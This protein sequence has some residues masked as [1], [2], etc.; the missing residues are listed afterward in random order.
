ME[1]MAAAIQTLQQQ[2]AQTQ[3]GNQLLRDRIQVFEASQ[4]AAGT[5]QHGQG[6]GLDSAEVI[7]ALRA[8]PEA[9]ARLNKPKGLIDPRGLGNLKR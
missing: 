3:N 8:L 6:G 5:P 9:L 7:Q 4:A 1:E 2:M